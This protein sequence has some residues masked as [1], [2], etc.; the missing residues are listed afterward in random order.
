[1]TE[2]SAKLVT[3]NAFIGT[4]LMGHQFEDDVLKVGVSTLKVRAGFNF[5]APPL[6]EKE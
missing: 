5:Q 1:M 2:V 3:E 4:A 6:K